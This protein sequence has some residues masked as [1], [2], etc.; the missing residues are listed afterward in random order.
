MKKL[1]YSIILAG[2]CLF[3]SCESFTDIQPKGMNLLSTTTDLEMLLNTEFFHTSTDMREVAAD[4]IYGATH[5]PSLLSQPGI[6]RTKIIMEL[7]DT[8]MEKMAELTNSDGDFTAWYKYIGK[9][10]NPV[11]LMIDDATGD[12]KVKDQL[13]AEALTMRAYFHWLLVNKFAKAYNPATAETDPA[14]PYVTHEW[15]LTKPT[16][17]LTVA[18]VYENILKDVDDA[19]ALNSLPEVNINRMRMSKAC[20][21]A[22]KALALMSMQNYTDAAD[23][24]QDALDV[25]DAIMDY[26]TSTTMF[27]GVIMGGK[28]PVILRPTL[29]CP[30]DYF[31]IYDREIMYTL[32]PES[33]AFFEEGHACLSKMTTFNHM[34][35]FVMDYA[36]MSLGLP[37]GQYLV[38]YDQI[39]GWNQTGIKS[40]YM[41]LILAECAIH[42]KQYDAAMGYLDQLR[43]KR[44]DPSVYAPLKG[45]VSTKED[46]ILN[47]KKTSHGECI[48]SIYNFIQKKRWN[49]L[50]DFKQS[51]HRDLLG[52]PFSI[53]PGSKLW[54]FP[55]PMNAVVNN[56]NFLPHN[57]ESVQ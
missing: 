6:T 29:E 4:V 42:A 51:W 47:L 40:T 35:D 19:I 30:E 50:A 38:D 24:A 16:E 41:Y 31:F 54:V 21:Y 37:Y 28:Y 3:S 8:N 14:I 23:A 2:A 7:D 22:V 49:E 26:N 11:L 56:S 13:K 44:I 27:S 5:I 36:Q 1:L 46:A 34:F 33:R 12:Q 9:V 25:N 55:F 48:Y 43:E 32:T 10:A 17:K 20:P 39:S 18:K 53:E 45:N 57:Y 15:D 52:Q